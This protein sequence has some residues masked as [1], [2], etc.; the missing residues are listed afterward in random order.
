MVVEK[1]TLMAQVKARRG[2]LYPCTRVIKPVCKPG[3][4]RR[5]KMV[6]KGLVI[7][8]VL[9]SSTC[10]SLEAPSYPQQ[11]RVRLIQESLFLMR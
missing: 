8:V 10:V 7:K 6:S 9:V 11:I 5:G 3:S 1:K 4:P 2:K